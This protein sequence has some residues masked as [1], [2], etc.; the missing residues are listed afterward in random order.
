MNPLVELLTREVARRYAQA[1][2]LLSPVTGHCA[3]VAAITCTVAAEWGIRAELR[4][5]RRLD[6]CTAR[7]AQVWAELPDH[8]VIIHSRRRGIVDVVGD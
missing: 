3:E 2:P 5:G 4:A 1:E 8:N 6:L 7:G